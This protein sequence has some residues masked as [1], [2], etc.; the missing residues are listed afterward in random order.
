MTLFGLGEG[1]SGT[2]IGARG[3]AEAVGSAR[4]RTR[5]VQV[6][7][8]AVALAGPWLGLPR[9]D[10]GLLTTACLYGIA[11]TGLNLMFGYAGMLSLGNGLFLGLGA[12]TT[13]IVS[14]RLHWPMV[15]SLLVAVLLTVA[16]AVPLG[17]LLVR[18]SGHYFA[19][20]TLGLAMAF[21][22]LLLVFPDLTGGASGLTTARRL[23]LGVLTVSSDLQWYGLVVVL[24]GLVVLS[25]DRMVAGKRG[26]ILRLVRQDELAAEVLGVPVHRVKLAAFVAGVFFTALAGALLFVWQGLIVPDAI[27]VVPSV[28]LAALVVV[29]GMGY[30]LGGLIGAVAILWV[31][32]L[33]NGFGHY[34]LLVYGVLFLAVMFFLRPGLEGGLVGLWARL[35]Q[36]GRPR[37]IPAVAPSPPQATDGIRAGRGLEVR[38]ARRSFGGLVA[39]DG[40]DLSVPPG[41]V[42]GLIGANGAGKSTL[43]NL[44]SGVERLQA[45]MV[46][47]NGEDVSRLSPAWR[48]RRGIARTF[49]VP[50]LVEGLTVVEN[51]ALGLEA[52][53]PSVFRRSSSTE[54]LA[55]ARARRAL[56]GLALDDLADRPVQALG[57]GERKSVELARAIVRDAP[58]LLLDEPAVGL[59][60]EEV[61]ALRAHLDRLRRQGASVLV[62]DHNLDFIRALADRVYVMDGG[63]VVREGRP[64]ELGSEPAPAMQPSLPSGPDHRREV[65][66]AGAGKELVVS[67][68]S[69][70]YG[71]VTVLHDVAFAVAAGEV[72]GIVGPNGAGKTTL[73]NALAGLNRRARGEVL[74]GG[75]SLGGAPPDR[76]VARGL[77]LV[78][79]GRQIIGSITVRANL[80]V[81]ATARGRWRSDRDH[82]RRMARVFDLFPRLGELQDAP[83]GALSGGEQQMLAIA[84]ALMTQPSVLLLDEPSQGLAPAMV[85]VVV[86]ALE[87]LKGTVTM[88]VVEQNLQV[89]ES[90]ADRLI[91]LRLGRVV[92]GRPHLGEAGGEPWG[93]GGEPERFADR[94]PREG[95]WHP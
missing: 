73:L 38:G 82:R 30:R 92:E 19:V 29:G 31:Q 37:P 89:L 64:D 88:V 26:R 55:F 48:A 36:K 33:L 84:R 8:L 16:V 74:L 63:R 71:A 77:A 10:A 15:P 93:Q 24:T 7:L 46:G 72:L 78:P 44:V 65:A 95:L 62:V 2:R 50:R 43:L 28:Q 3:L 61:E 85:A 42:V 13:A 35:N 40:V 83:G 80:E 1:G 59:T 25:L 70:G 86:T 49:Q 91:A 21:A 53:E 69:A 90:L 20:A 81:T 32:A 56:A 5:V 11:A 66:T 54:A 58:L 67:G 51:V 23:D 57:G 45:G 41:T 79:E 76:R 9:L 60:L 17:W 39:V 14:Q 34:E 22:E 4:L 75:R 27:G 94:G 12:Y 6:C 47:L 87:Q 68:L 52:V 18:L